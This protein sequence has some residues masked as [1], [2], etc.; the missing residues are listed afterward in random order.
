MTN[1][2]RDHLNPPNEKEPRM[3][4]CEECHEGFTYDVDEDGTLI[5]EK[6][7]HPGCENGWI[8]Y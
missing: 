5:K 4:E 1:Y 2:E 8:E 7:T 3:T 6:C